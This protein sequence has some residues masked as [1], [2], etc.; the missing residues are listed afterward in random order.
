MGLFR[1]RTE[2]Q[3]RDV[4]SPDGFVFAVREAPGQEREIRNPQTG[5]WRPESEVRFSHLPVFEEYHRQ[6]YRQALA[7]KQEGE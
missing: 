3:H 2:W 6:Q 5:E 1:K 7:G 4:L